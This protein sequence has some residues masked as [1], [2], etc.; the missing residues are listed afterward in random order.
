MS[1]FVR[2][3]SASRSSGSPADFQV[4]MRP[5]LPRGRYR[6]SHVALPH[7]APP[8]PAAGRGL[9]ASRDGGLTMDTLEMGVDI[10]S[11]PALLTT[12]ASVLGTY[13]G[14]TWTTALNS[15]TNMLS[16]TQTG[17]QPVT[18]YP[19]QAE[20]ASTLSGVIGVYTVVTVNADA[21]VTLDGMVN[22]AN[23]LTYEIDIDGAVGEHITSG[24]N[25]A[26][27]VIPV[28]T[29]SF[30]VINWK[31]LENAAQFVDVQ[32]DLSTLRVVVRDG[33]GVALDDVGGLRADWMMV[34][35]RQRWGVGR[36]Q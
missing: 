20:A 18:F 14:G 4:G 17:G 34:L 24:G 25:T 28:D 32:Q 10:Y 26:A 15:A 35:E 9:V 16:L 11:L 23:Q 2:I 8:V 29:N 19:E 22:L 12:L 5:A 21:T 27:F 3:N 1:R 36:L 6:L 33:T 30:G 13:T 31:S 7:T